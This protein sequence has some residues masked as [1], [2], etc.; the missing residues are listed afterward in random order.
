MSKFFIGDIINFYKMKDQYL[1]SNKRYYEYLKDEFY[2]AVDTKE[3][4]N[5][6]LY[7]ESTIGSHYEII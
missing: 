7:D 5:F 4:F 2:L 3:P 6:G 1:L